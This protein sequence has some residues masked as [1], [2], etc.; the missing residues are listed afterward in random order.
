MLKRAIKFDHA[1]KLA[2]P[3][4]LAERPHRAP[5]R[6][7][8]RGVDRLEA[9][10]P[11]KS[12]TPM[13]ERLQR[14]DLCYAIRDGTGEAASFVW[15]ASG[16]GVYFYELGADI[17]VPGSVAYFYD[18][19]TLPEARGQGL[20][21]ELL[22]GCVA[23]LRDAD[24]PLERCEAWT[25]A[26]NAAAIKA[27]GRAGFGVYESYRWLAVLPARLHRGSPKIGENGR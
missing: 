1:L 5:A 7:D 2:R 26:R 19:F 27:F 18:A 12:A 3:L 9:R 21:P 20:M 11:Y 24:L 25:S 10:I 15:V 13:K 16:R 23:A 14:G 22:A 17:W 6:L 8:E 4:E